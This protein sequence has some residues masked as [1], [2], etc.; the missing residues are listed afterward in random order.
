MLGLGRSTAKRNSRRICV[1]LNTRQVRWVIATRRYWKAI[2]D[3]AVKRNP[4]VKI[5]AYLYHNTLPAPV[6]D[7]KLNKNITGEF[8]IYGARDGWYPMSQE[9]DQWYRDQWAGL[10]KNRNV[11][12]LRAELLIQ[13]VCHAQHDDVGKRANSSSSR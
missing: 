2:Y 3:L 7:I 12:R 9:E 10:G 13:H 4:N 5:S 8:V 6:T 1:C 11:T